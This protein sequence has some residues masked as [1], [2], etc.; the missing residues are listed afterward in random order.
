M[1]LML[2]LAT[3]GFLRTLGVQVGEKRDSSESKD[4]QKLVQVS[5]VFKNRHHIQL[6]DRM[7]TNDSGA[8]D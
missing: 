2:L 6:S 1:E 4:P 7:G 8:L 3:I 5:A